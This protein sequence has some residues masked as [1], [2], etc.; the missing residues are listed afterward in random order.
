VR[1]KGAAAVLLLLAAA[2][3]ADDWRPGPA[4]AEYRY[5]GGS[6]SYWGHLFRGYASM[7]VDQRTRPFARFDMQ[8]DRYYDW[9]GTAVLGAEQKIDQDWSGHAAA[10][11]TQGDLHKANQTSS[12]IFVDIGFDRRAGTWRS[13]VVYWLSRGS[14]DPV[15]APKSVEQ[16]TFALAA[17]SASAN[18][19]SITAPEDFWYHQ[20]T[21]FL[22][23]P[24]GPY[25]SLGGSLIGWTRSDTGSNGWAERLD[26]E[27]KLV[28]DLSLTA[29]VQL[30]QPRGRAGQHY[31]SV[32]LRYF[33]V[34]PGNFSL[35]D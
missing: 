13:G 33:F 10:G 27:L 22:G 32:G 9:E 16:E 14:A 21:L 25:L 3:S 23:G 29:A 11:A 20:G 7:N 5:T 2:A 34:P 31:S 18:G 24:I 35:E 8:V 28:T 1:G 26:L 4:S 15:G 6:D 12:S 17:S 19:T 30:E